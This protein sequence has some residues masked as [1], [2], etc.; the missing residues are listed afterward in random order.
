MDKPVKVL[1]CENL[2]LS[3]ANESLHIRPSLTE[4][5]PGEACDNLKSMCLSW[6]GCVRESHQSKNPCDLVPG[7]SIILAHLG[8]DHHLRRVLVGHN[9]VGRLV[10]GWQPL[11]AFGFAKAYAGLAKYLFD[12]YLK[13]APDELAD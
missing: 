11:G 4:A 9:K 13:I 7:C 12:R 10:K 6:L 1:E 5:S 8:L 3:L 2:A